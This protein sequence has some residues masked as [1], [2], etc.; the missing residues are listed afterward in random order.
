MGKDR[1]KDFQGV[2]SGGECLVVTCGPS[3][4]Q[5][6]DEEL[7]SLA[8][9]RF[10]IAIKQ[11]YLRCRDFADLVLLNNVN[12]RKLD[13]DRGRTAVFLASVGQ[14]RPVFERAD[15]RTIT[16][17][18]LPG[19]R[20]EEDLPDGW[21][22]CLENSLVWKSSYN[23][24]LL[25]RS[26]ERPFGPGI[27][28]EQAIYWAVHLGVSRL[29]VAGWDIGSPAKRIEH[30]DSGRLKGRRV[31]FAFPKPSNLPSWARSVGRC[32]RRFIGPPLAGVNYICGRKYNCAIGGATS[33]E[34]E[35][36]KA[37]SYEVYRW[38]SKNGVELE[39]ISH[40]SEADERIPRVEV[41]EV[42]GR[43]DY[44]RF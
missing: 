13:I 19:T 37:K 31:S 22:P 36:I 39:L 29:V 9:G 10:V 38:L 4:N 40:F 26:L 17:P 1:L 24:F 33:G 5:L 25:E 42:V 7:R 8:D 34:L 28:Y 44:T 41:D 21:D 16:V 6:S 35:L 43:S 2:C 15:W 20:S 32:A 18:V 27:F 12:N 30:F 23:D 3:L 11:A 14:G